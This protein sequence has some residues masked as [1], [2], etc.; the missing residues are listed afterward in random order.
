MKQLNRS[1]LL[2]AMMGMAYRAE[3]N[4]TAGA[5]APV[6]AQSD[7]EKAAAATKAAEIRA[8]LVAGIKANFNDK[9][10]VIEQSFHFRKVVE[11]L[12]NE[13]GTPKLDEKNKPVTKTTKRPSVH[14]PIPRPSVEGIVEILTAE[15]NE[16]E[17]ELL[18]EAV[19]AVVLDRAR[20]LI[21]DDLE[22]TA[23]N[24]DY[25]KLS[26]TTIANLPKAERR[27]GGISAEL[28]AEWAADYIAVMLQ[29]TDKPLDRVE[30]ASKVFL[31]KF[32]ASKTNKPVLKVLQGQLAIYTSATT[33][34]EE[35]AS[36]I[37]FLDKKMETLLATDET[38]LLL[39]L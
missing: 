23:E 7:E 34:G 36:C 8:T 35:F 2:A 13:D 31:S 9:V 32:A 19:N 30:L 3:A 18:L 26:W 11:E 4:E 16:K 1:Y 28:W 29:A 33:R 38:N 21:N 12:K 20:D 39:N 27:G 37:E 14:L 15:G 25:S 17:L 22:I 5:A 6:T 24:F 10:D